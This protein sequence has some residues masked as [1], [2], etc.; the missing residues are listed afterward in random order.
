MTLKERINALK[1]S[2][3]ISHRF[4]ASQTDKSKD[5]S[6]HI[7]KRNMTLEELQKKTDEID[8]QFAKYEQKMAD[9]LLKVTASSK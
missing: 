9:P 8:Q 7:K 2:K 1:A 4:T 5:V 6:P 3:K